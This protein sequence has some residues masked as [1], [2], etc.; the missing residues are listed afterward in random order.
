MSAPG[1]FRWCGKP[2]SELSRDELL[3]VIDYLSKRLGEYTTP[4]AV[5]AMARGRV[6]QWKR[7]Y[8]RC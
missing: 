7:G 6:E 4:R 3:L 5:D 1:E 8:A 2:A